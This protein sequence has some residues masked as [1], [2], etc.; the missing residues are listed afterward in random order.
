MLAVS[1]IVA[2]AGQSVGV[3]FAGS[4]SLHLFDGEGK[5]LARRT[6]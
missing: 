1:A 2:V 3:D 5:E 6:A 4:S